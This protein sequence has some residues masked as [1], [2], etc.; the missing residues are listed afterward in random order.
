MTH[1]E[2][3]TSGK[4]LLGPST[5]EGA[6]KG[7]FC[8]NKPIKAGSLV[9]LYLGES[10]DTA[11]TAKATGSDAIYHNTSNSTYV[12]GDKAISY[13]PWIKDPLDLNKVNCTIKYN[14]KKK[15]LEVRASLID[16]EPHEE[17]F[18]SYGDE[19]WAEHLDEAPI[20]KI[21]KAY[22]AVTEYTQYINREGERENAANR[23]GEDVEPPRKVSKRTITR[24]SREYARN[25]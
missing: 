11:R 19:F 15:R 22:P 20:H 13:G 7:V 25:S 2:G 6:G 16:I 8:G 24:I 18:I 23:E 3:Y 12:I 10:V 9:T 1:L 5:I 17:I 21:V 14:N 4:V